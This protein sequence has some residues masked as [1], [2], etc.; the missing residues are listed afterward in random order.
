M[1]FVIFEQLKYKWMILS[2]VMILKWKY[3][4]TN[5]SKCLINFLLYILLYIILYIIMKVSINLF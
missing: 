5:L 3:N 2:E 4:D 1:S